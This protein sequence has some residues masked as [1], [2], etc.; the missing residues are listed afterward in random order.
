MNSDIMEKI[1]KKLDNI[2]EVVIDIRINQ[3]KQEKSIL[4]NEKEIDKLYKEHKIIE[5]KVESQNKFI[6]KIIGL[7]VGLGGIVTYIIVKL[8]SLLGQAIK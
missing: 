3:G 7:S 1:D 4:Y 5:T 6:T 8:P 2:N